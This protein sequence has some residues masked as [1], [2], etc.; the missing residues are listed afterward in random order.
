MKKA[1]IHANL[2]DYQDFKED[3]YMIFEDKILEVGPMKAFNRVDEIFDCRGR[4]VVPGLV[5]AHSHIY[6][7][8]ARG[9]N[10]PCAAKNFTEFLEQTWWKLDSALDEEAVYYSALVSGVE[11]LKNG[12]TT[13]VDHHAS[14]RQIR[15]SLNTLKKGLCD[16]VGLR[17]IF[18]FETSDRFPLEECIEENIDFARSQ[19]TSSAAGVFGMHANMTL[20]NDSLKSIKQAIGVMPIHIHVGESLDDCDYS[21][22]VL[23]KSVVERLEHF[24]LLNQRSILSHCI[25]LNEEDKDMLANKELYIAFNP[26][27]NM[28]NGV[29]LPDIKGLM[30]RNI[31]CMLGNDGLGFYFARDI[32]TLL[33]A[34]NL[35]YGHTQSLG[36]NKIIEVIENNYDYAGKMLGCKLGKF[37]KGYEADFAVIS[38][39]S[40]TPID[41]SNILGHFF[42]GLLEQFRPDY[43]WCKGEARVIQGNVKKETEKIYSE[44]QKAASNVWKRCE[45]MKL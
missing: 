15:G 44:A 10:A 40:P 39:T 26:T 45:E 27:S 29:G 31:K 12:V 36:L 3:Y 17:G 35:K 22:K 8:F 24:E 38:Y 2:F 41:S 25:Y 7:T 4:L 33:Y 20:S 23:E 21:Q 30:Q 19:K 13:V 28:N 42:Y 16:E 32:Q 11:F 14:G 43:V 6:S 34:A 1:L 9:W 37:K 5:N 18:C